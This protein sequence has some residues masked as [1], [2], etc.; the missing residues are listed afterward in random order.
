MMSRSFTSA[1]LYSL[2]FA[3]VAACSDDPEPSA[4]ADQSDDAAVEQ[5]ADLDTQDTGNSGG[6]ELDGAEQPTAV[7]IV[8]SSGETLTIDSQS[9]EVWLDDPELRFSLSDLSLGWSEAISST[10]NYDP[11]FL[12][13]PPE[14][15]GPAVPTDLGARR[16]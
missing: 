1:V 4:D 10:V 16:V 13:E 2:L 11:T 12:Y 3:S 5:D 7:E 9:F 15:A 8:A 6:D 14:L